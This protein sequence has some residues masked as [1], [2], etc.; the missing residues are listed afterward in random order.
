MLLGLLPRLLPLK[1]PGKPLPQLPQL[2]L[3]SP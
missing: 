2:P 1:L 3:A